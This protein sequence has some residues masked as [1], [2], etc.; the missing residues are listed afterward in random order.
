MTRMTDFPSTS[1]VLRREIDFMCGCVNDGRVRV[2]SFG[3]TRRSAILRA[4]LERQQR[5]FQMFAA[6]L[7]L[8][9]LDLERKATQETLSC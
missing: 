5:M 1:F 6:S 7:S 9:S 8:P 4:H 3:P 2:R